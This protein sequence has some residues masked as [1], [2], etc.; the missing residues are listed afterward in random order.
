M[1]ISTITQMVKG[2]TFGEQ[3]AGIASEMAAGVARAMF[4]ND[5]AGREPFGAEGIRVHT[6]IHVGGR[7]DMKLRVEFT[8]RP[9]PGA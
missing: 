9:E 8:V 6:V 7:K 4:L 5:E 2:E 3:L 1:G